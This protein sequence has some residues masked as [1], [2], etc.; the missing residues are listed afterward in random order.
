MFVVKSA[1]NTFGKQQRHLARWGDPYPPAG[2]HGAGTIFSGSI[3]EQE[4]RYIASSQMTN[5]LVLRREG[6]GQRGE[7]SRAFSRQSHGPARER[8]ES[9]VYPSRSSEKGGGFGV[10]L[11][12]RYTAVGPKKVHLQI[13]CRVRVGRMEGIKSHDEQRHLL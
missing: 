11:S 2:L 3:I 10:L 9:Y 12:P 13:G 5:L 1:R 4:P 8:N 7:G 6:R